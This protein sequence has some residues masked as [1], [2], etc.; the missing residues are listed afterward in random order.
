MNGAVKYGSMW[1][2]KVLDMSATVPVAARLAMRAFKAG[3]SRHALPAAGSTEA[4][5]IAEASVGVMC[6]VSG[7]SSASCASNTR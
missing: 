3:P 2:E 6:I 5:W 4:H 7:T 1:S